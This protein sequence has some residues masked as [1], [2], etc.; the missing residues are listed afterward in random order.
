M[1]ELRGSGLYGDDL[2]ESLTSE[3]RELALEQGATQGGRVPV[4]FRVLVE[5]EPRPLQMALRADLH[6]IG[7]EVLANAFRHARASHIELDINY[8]HQ[9]L[10]MR[11][12]DDGIGMDPDFLAPGGRKGHWGLPGIRERARA[13]GGRLEVWSELARGTEV[14]LTLPAKIAYERSRH[15]GRA[16][17]KGQEQPGV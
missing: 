4:A 12:R 5:G 2:I 8:G 9:M 7:R 15:P 6:S 3:A 11:I 10:R 16:T 1:Q 17:P 13:I 14:E